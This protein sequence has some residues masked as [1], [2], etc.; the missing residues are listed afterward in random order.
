MKSWIRHRISDE[1][2]RP[3]FCSSDRDAPFSGFSQSISR[4]AGAG[5]ETVG[6]EDAYREPGTLLVTGVY[7]AT[8]STVSQ[9]CPWDVAGAL[10]SITDWAPKDLLTGTYIT[11][12]S[13]LDAYVRTI[14]T[15]YLHER[16]PGLGIPTLREWITQ[17]CHLG[18]FK[19]PPGEIGGWF[20]DYGG[21]N[22]SF[23]KNDFVASVGSR[24]YMTTEEGHIGLGPMGTQP[25]KWLS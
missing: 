17:A 15:D 3:A 21:L 4:D 14:C 9:T 22:R 10:K 19:I 25:G 2:T 7:C 11:G 16:W 18:F 6:D 8:I 5:E 20:D 12:E 24:T 1:A 23:I 13:L